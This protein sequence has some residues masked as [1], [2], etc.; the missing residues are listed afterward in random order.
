M[1]GI[2]SAVF[3]EILFFRSSSILLWSGAS[4]RILGRLED[5]VREVSKHSKRVFP[6]F[7]LLLLTLS[8]IGK[9][10]SAGRFLGDDAKAFCSSFCTLDVGRVQYWFAMTKFVE[11]SSATLRSCVAF[12]TSFLSPSPVLL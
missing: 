11:A 3:I 7:G 6:L 10:I 8:L 2:V 5:S 12:R 1:S 9:D 4:T